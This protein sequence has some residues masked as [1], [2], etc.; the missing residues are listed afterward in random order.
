MSKL[1]GFP[2]TRQDLF[3]PETSFYY[4]IRIKIFIAKMASIVPCR[5]FIS[6]FVRLQP[7]KP[8]YGAQ[9]NHYSVIEIYFAYY[10]R[11]VVWWIWGVLE[12]NNELLTHIGIIYIH[13]IHSLRQQSLFIC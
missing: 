7:V 8:L 11:A 6:S 9:T 12:S 2:Y 4:K 1:I 3:A 5:F 13:R 10:V